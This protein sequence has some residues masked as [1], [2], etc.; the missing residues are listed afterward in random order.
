MRGPRAFPALVPAW[1]PGFAA[2]LLSLGSYWIAIWAFTQAP[3]ALVSAL[4][5]TSI[6]FAMLIGVAFLGETGG[7]WRW[8][9]AGLIV[10]GIVL[11][12]V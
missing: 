1:R 10:A 5:E 3:V 6:L 2:G 11:L 9:A 12:R 8:L 7:R 4:R